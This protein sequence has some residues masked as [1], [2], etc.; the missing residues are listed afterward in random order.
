MDLN[1]HCRGRSVQRGGRRVNGVKKKKNTLQRDVR[2]HRSIILTEGEE[3]LEQI[4]V[5]KVQVKK[6]AKVFQLP[7]C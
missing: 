2:R 1:I 6:F 3:E 5:A 4:S 7:R